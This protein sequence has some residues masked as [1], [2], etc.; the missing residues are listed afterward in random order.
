MRLP[1]NLSFEKALFIAKHTA[2]YLGRKQI[3]LSL[4][5]RYPRFKVFGESGWLKELPPERLGTAKYYDS[6]CNVYRTAKIAVDINRMVIRNGFT[7]R[8]F[9]VPASGGFVITSAK[10]VVTE[11]FTTEGPDKE[12]VVFRSSQELTRLIDYYLSHEDERLAIA[13]RGMKKVLSAHTY[14]HRVAEMFKVL[15]AELAGK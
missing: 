7:Q 5:K 9:D 3:I 4:V 15:S 13:E 1:P 2:G 11:F 12:M 6:L 10:P 14:D 8:V